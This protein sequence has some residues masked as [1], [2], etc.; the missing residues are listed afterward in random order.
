MNN[1]VIPHELRC[2]ASIPELTEI[3]KKLYRLEKQNKKI[4]DKID[5]LQ[6]TINNTEIL[7]HTICASLDDSESESESE[8]ECEN[9]CDNCCGQ[10]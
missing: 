8:S 9:G 1:I 7:C 10:W 5:K 6:N 4:L 2:T 3:M